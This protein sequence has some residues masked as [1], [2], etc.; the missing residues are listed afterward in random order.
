MNNFFRF[1]LVLVFFACENEPYV[2]GDLLDPTTTNPV[3]E[4]SSFSIL[5]EH[6]PSLTENVVLTFDGTDTY[7][8][9]IRY[10]CDI[11][12]LVATYDFNGGNVTVNDS[13]QT[14]SQTANNFNKRVAYKF[15]D[16]ANAE[17]ESFFVEISYF[18]GLPIIN[19]N[20]NNQLIDSKDDYVNGFVTVQGGLGFEDIQN[21]EIKIRGRGNSTW[22]HPKKPYQLKFSDKTPFLGMAKDKK[23]IFL[24]EYS[25]K[26]L[27]RNK[28]ALEMGA[29]SALDWTPASEY[30]EVFVNQVYSGTYLITQKVEVKSN[31]L[32]LPDNGYLVEIDQ[33]YR[34]DDDEVF[35]Q[36]TIFTQN[37]ESNVFNIKEPEVVL[38]SSE[39]NIIKDYVN[40][41]EAALFGANFQDANI[42]YEAF[43][44]VQSFI[45]WY[46]I[47]EIAKSVDAQWYSSIYFNYTPGDKLKMGP[48][49][50]FDLS[51]GNVDYADATYTEGFWIKDNP[52]YERL[53]E[54]PNFE[55]QVKERFMFF[56]NNRNELIGKM[57]QYKTYLELSQLENYQTWPTLGIYVWP[58]PVFFDTH[59]AEV[60]HLENW[61]SLRMDWLYSQFN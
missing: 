52:W 17:F 6:N 49:W 51:F 13:V 53:F 48:L 10:I 34:L 9:A 37:Y 31:R 46:L 14:N 4:L 24:A 26:S 42:G 2:G 39:Y 45:D 56:Y 5:A 11:D 3:V 33:D 44:D 54:D 43:I 35:F 50:D 20:T 41:F 36:P 19:I 21:Q 8:A 15:Y 30:A 12:Q 38:D 61:F 18:T 16:V 58:N 60:D 23:W 59:A 40:N 25:D 55:L 7:T 57:N 1:L 28:I 29:I 47:M 27:M 32:D 22:L